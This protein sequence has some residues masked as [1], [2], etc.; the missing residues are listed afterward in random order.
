MKK[1]HLLF[2]LLSLAFS[3]TLLAQGGN[4]GNAEATVNSKKVSINYGKPTLRGRDVLS[5]APVG[6][7]WRVG[8]NEATEIAS[9]GDLM[10][11]GKRLKAGK[12]S[13][14]VRK[15]GDKQW[16]LAFHPTVGIFGQPELKEGYVAEMPL[17]LTTAP[18]TAEQLVITIATRNNNAEIAIHWGTSLLKGLFGVI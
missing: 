6:M 2:S 11:G 3:I 9:T 12:Y 14:W 10:V 16:S 8:M 5:M 17:E 1:R 7:V 13:L 18:Q 15:I 4:R